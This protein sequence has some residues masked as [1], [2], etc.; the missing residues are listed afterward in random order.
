ML[1]QTLI[2]KTVFINQQPAFYVI[3]PATSAESHIFH[4]FRRIQ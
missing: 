3:I 2:V 4:A 1:E